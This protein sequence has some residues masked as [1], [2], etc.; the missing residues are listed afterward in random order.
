MK[1]HVN[2]VLIVIVILLAL[3]VFVP[4]FRSGYADITTSLGDVVPDI[5]SNPENLDCVPGPGKDADYYTTEKSQGLCKG[6][7]YV[8]KMAREYKI[9]DA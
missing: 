7:A 4:R 6:Q 8:H 1:F 9:L 2:Q 3:W 5:F